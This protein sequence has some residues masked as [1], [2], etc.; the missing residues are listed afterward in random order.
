MSA[1]DDRQP[2]GSFLM[3]ACIAETALCQPEKLRRA[4]STLI[5]W[6]TAFKQLPPTLIV[7]GV[8]RRMITPLSHK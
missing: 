8:R 3:R 5:Q 2:V 4:T 1:Y 6:K 7:M